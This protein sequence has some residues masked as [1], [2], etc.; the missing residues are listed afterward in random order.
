M[1]E[2]SSQVRVRSSTHPFPSI[3]THT[4]NPDLFH[5][6]TIPNTHNPLPLSPTHD[7]PRQR[8]PYDVSFVS[9]LFPP[10]SKPS[11]GDEPTICQLSI[12]IQSVHCPRPCKRYHRSPA[13]PGVHT[14]PDA[15]SLPRAASRPSHP[16]APVSQPQPCCQPF[17]LSGTLP[18]PSASSPQ[19]YRFI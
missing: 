2:S 14:P 19:W 16:P 6:R 10:S 5:P 15:H 18:Y 7:S 1:S 11:P 12:L 17:P 13:N 4:P 9:Y 8:T 3:F